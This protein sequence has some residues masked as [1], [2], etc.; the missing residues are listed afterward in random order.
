MMQVIT[1]AQPTTNF[2]V[3]ATAMCR[4]LDAPA[5]DRM[6]AILAFKTVM[7]K[8]TL[9]YEGDAS[10]NSYE[11]IEGVLKLYKLMPDGRRQI[12]GFMY[13]GHFVGLANKGI[14]V[15]TAEAV[16]EVTLCRYPSARLTPLVDE[17]PALGRRL[18]DLAS[19]ELIEAQNQ[20]L[21][22]GRKTPMEKVCSFLLRLI[23][24]TV[25]VDKEPVLLLLPMTRADIADYLG[26]TI[27]TVSRTFTKLKTQGV[28]RMR[29][30]CRMLECNMD[31]LC[32]I[33]EG[34]DGSMGI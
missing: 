10:D 8:Q 33:A 15:H 6:S 20:L 17:M 9:F 31:A 14:Y 4:G 21:V 2:D 24:Q 25:D 7:P 28:I 11:V 16:T 26:L 13:P 30:N 19:D 5:R 22:L 1:T 29:E 23:E 3:S 34:D 18:F 32:D 27:E 12:T